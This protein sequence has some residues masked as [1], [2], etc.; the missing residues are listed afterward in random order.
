M[1]N[2]EQVLNFV[3]DN[4]VKFIRLAFCDVHGNQKTITVMAS[5]LERVFQSGVSFD[6]SDIDG[7]TNVESVSCLLFPDPKT[8]KLLPWNPA[9]GK[10]LRL[11]CDI[12]KTNGE[13]FESDFRNILKNAVDKLLSLGYDCKVGIESE[14]YLFKCDEDGAPTMTPLDNAGYMDIEPLDKCENIR[15]EICLTL[16][17]MGLKPQSSQHKRGPGQNEID[18]KYDTPVN[19][20]DNYITYKSVI[21][22]MAAKNGLFAS[23]L[24]KP[25]RDKSGSGLHIHVSL[26][27]DG[28]NIFSFA[29]EIAE[30]FIEGILTYI[31]EITLFMN[32]LTNSYAR[33]GSFE[34]PQYVAWSR[35][36]RAQ[37]VRIPT[38][39]EK[40]KRIE[41]RS[42]DPACS[43]Y[44][45][46]AL[47]IHAG[48]F[49]IEHSLRVRRPIEQNLYKADYG[50]LDGLSSLPN[51]LKE[52]VELSASSTFVKNILPKYA[53][54]K[55]I[56]EKRD[57]CMS[58]LQSDDKVEFE[59][60]RYF[61]TV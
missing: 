18:F 30:N 9:Y 24:P 40:N 48:I 50:F 34:A 41:I 32:P 12:K 27:K 31:D 44:I 23:F 11:F 14:F 59:I 1:D 33:F 7:F 10:V 20:V 17:E 5:E 39:S 52:A 15:R 6:A 56:D 3:K 28:E 51:S 16:D 19:A 35:N 29:P 49:G 47:L 43:P 26:Y 54:E 21:K 37:L 4:D 22:T 13:P 46:L 36:S 25:F 58:Y 53:F 61:A 55:Y 60:E 42:A 8:M 2:F 45:A 38:S 57:E